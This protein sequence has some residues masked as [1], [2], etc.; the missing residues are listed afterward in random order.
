LTAEAFTNAGDRRKIA[1][2]TTSLRGLLSYQRY[3]TAEGETNLFVT[4]HET[5]TGI[6]GLITNFHLPQSS[7]LLL[8]AAFCGRDLLARA[9]KEA[10]AHKYRFYSYGDA[11]LII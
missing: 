11:M 5:I 3:G 2:G 7:L 9:Y 8:T 4:P 10:I 1:L 6:E